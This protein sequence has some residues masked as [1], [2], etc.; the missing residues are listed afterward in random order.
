MDDYSSFNATSQHDHKLSEATTTAFEMYQDPDINRK[1][2]MTSDNVID[3]IGSV[4]RK[5]EI[6]MGMMNKL[7]ELQNYS[8]LEFIIDDSGS[9]GSISD[10]KDPQGRSMTRWQ[11]AVSRLKSLIEIIAH[12]PTPPIIIKFLNRHD[13]VNLVHN[14]EPPEQFIQKANSEIDRV[15]YREPDGRT[16][17]RE[18]LERS[19]REG[20]GKRVSRYFFCDGEPN[21][22]ENDKN[23]I[24]QMLIRRQDPAGNPMTFL[25]C[26]GDDQEAE[27]MKEVEEVAPYCSESDDFADEREEVLNDQGMALPFTKGFYLVCQLVAA[28]NPDDLDAMDESVPLCKATLDNILG[29][30]QAEQDYRHYFTCFQQAQQKRVVDPQNRIDGIKKQ[31]DWSPYYND[32]KSA[33]VAKNIPAV[34]EFKRR[35][36]TGQPGAVGGQPAY[37]QQQP[38]YGQTAAQPYSQQQPGYGRPQTQQSS[39]GQQP[40][41]QPAYGQQPVHQPAYGQPQRPQ[42]QQQGYVQKLSSVLPPKMASMIPGQSSKPPQQGYQQ[43]QQQ[44]PAPQQGGYS[45]QPGYYP[46]PQGQPPQQGYGAP[47]GGAYPPPQGQQTTQYGAQPGGAYPPQGQPSYSPQQGQPPA[48]NTGVPGPAQGGY[49][50]PYNPNGPGGKR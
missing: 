15:T 22:G 14:G 18:S 26:T 9:M 5:Y 16:P 38:A 45:G 17:A 47:Q 4:F 48:H 28:M 25:S 35:I 27:W 44:Y 32:F 31:M 46:P 13:I 49:P 1:T 41:G 29:I 42:S 12:V 11:E 21:G 30:E 50:A 3:K 37:G 7:L 39:Y 24:K 43:Q 34:Q 10:S 6:P 19:L 8:Y 36:G 23:Q 20:Q 2:G 33:P 40:Y